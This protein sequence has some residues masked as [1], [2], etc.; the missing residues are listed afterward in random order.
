MKGQIILTGYD[1]NAEDKLLIVE[2]ENIEDEA[3][4][5]TNIVRFPQLGVSIQC[6][7]FSDAIEFLRTH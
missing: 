7:L 5:L 1:E 4:G 6:R 3:E 2:A